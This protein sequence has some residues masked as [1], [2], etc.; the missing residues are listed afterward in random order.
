MRVRFWYRDAGKALQT[1]ARCH[2][3]PE[4]SEAVG[5]GLRLGS[6]E[7]TTRCIQK[8]NAIV[9]PRLGIKEPAGWF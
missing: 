2:G 4:I 9:P 7:A 1:G 8:A 6:G 3:L 5:S